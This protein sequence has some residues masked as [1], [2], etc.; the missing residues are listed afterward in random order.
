MIKMLM[1]HAS[2]CISPHALYILILSHICAY[3]IDLAEQELEEQ[4]HAEDTNTDPKQGK[5]LVFYFE[6]LLYVLL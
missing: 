2:Y 3:V 5:P 6:A 1:F 4:A